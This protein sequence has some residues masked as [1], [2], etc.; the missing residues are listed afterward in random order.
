MWVCERLSEVGVYVLV[1]WW[2]VRVIVFGCV[3]EGC[4]RRV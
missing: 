3:G 1:G 2:D 4:M